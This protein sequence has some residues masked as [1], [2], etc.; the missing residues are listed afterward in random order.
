MLLHKLNK[1]LQNFVDVPQDSG[2]IYT[3]ITVSISNE[4][5]AI[6]KLAV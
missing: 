3:M 6:G 1:L 4:R 2:A 5:Q